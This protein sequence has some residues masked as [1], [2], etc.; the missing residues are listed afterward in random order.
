VEEA[1][2]REMIRH[3]LANKK[4]KAYRFMVDS[5]LAQKMTDGGGQPIKIE[6]GSR[7]GLAEK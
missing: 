7:C 2:L 6:M 5:C 4:S 1:E 3:T